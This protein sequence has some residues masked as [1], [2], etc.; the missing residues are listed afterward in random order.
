YRR[1]VAAAFQEGLS[2]AAGA[3]L[4]LHHY[5]MIGWASGIRYEVVGAQRWGV[6]RSQVLETLDYAFLN[7]GPAGMAVAAEATDDYLAAWTT[8]DGGDP[9]AWPE[10]WAPDPA[11]FRSGLD[12]TTSGLTAGERESLVAWYHDHQGEV[13]GHVRFLLYHDPGG[14]KAYR[15]RY[16]HVT[17]TLPKQMIP[18]MTLFTAAV[19]G[20]AGALRRAAYQ[21]KRYGVTRAELL[22]VLARVFGY[23][24]DLTMEDA[25]D[26]L[27][28]LLDRWEDS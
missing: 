14:I 28:P 15:D 6:A 16:E 23:A 3:L 17:R 8:D 2:S 26:V 18:L 25:T 12:F 5:T 24:G 27:G 21:A 9:S 22:L 13:P 19:T 1:W 20:R 10:G 7:A 11:A 4:F